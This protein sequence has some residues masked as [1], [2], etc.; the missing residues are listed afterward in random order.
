MRPRLILLAALGKDRVIG[1]DNTLPWHLPEDLKRF[2]ALTAG[3]AV[4]MGRKTF[5]S[6]VDRLGR[7]LPNRRS[8]VL[9]RDKRWA[10]D[11]KHRYTDPE[12]SSVRI[13]HDLGDLLACGETD[14]YVIGGAEIY[15]ATIDLA[16]ELDITEID[17]QVEGG[18][19]FFPEI[20]PDVWVRSSGPD[21]TSDAEQLTYRF[22][23]Y[24]R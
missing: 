8:L 5:T 13:F 24:R 9:T 16:D 19:A 6:I 14:I 20:D 15:A 23:T 17:I 18:D 1:K 10:E 4:A 2:K 3:K 12:V 22:V 7:P 11:C 21:L